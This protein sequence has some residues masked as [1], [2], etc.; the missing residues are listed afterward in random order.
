ML[1][2]ALCFLILA[3]TTFIIWRILMKAKGKA[4]KILSYYAIVITAVLGIAGMA[5]TILLTLKPAEIPVN[6]ST[7]II[8]SAESDGELLRQA[9]IRYDAGEYA[10]M[11]DIYQKP[12]L[13]QNPTAC[14]NMGYLYAKGIYVEKSLDK[15][16]D[17]F[18]RAIEC[19][20]EEAA[21]EILAMYLENDMKLAVEY[22]TENKDKDVMKKVLDDAF[23]GKSKFNKLSNDEKEKVLWESF[24]VEVA[25]GHTASNSALASTPYEIYTLIS[26]HTTLKAN[27]YETLTTYY[28][29]VSE[30]VLSDPGYFEYIF[31]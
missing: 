1:C 15:A 11:I 4:D 16:K 28:Y 30:W 2:I 24:L 18:D 5:I 17:Y 29:S 31:L 12:Q 9:A 21:L 26:T 20:C 8:Y 25:A 23:G 27:A 6:S 22:L 7:T 14:C 10:E 13:E 19:G 3:I